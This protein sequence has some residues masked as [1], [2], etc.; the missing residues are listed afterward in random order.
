MVHERHCGAA[1]FGLN[2]KSMA[3]AFLPKKTT[4]KRQWFC[5]MFL[6]S[7]PFRRFRSEINNLTRNTRISK[8]LKELR[9]L[10]KAPVF[11]VS[12]LQTNAPGLQRDF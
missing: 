7:H 11:W 5:M 6:L 8:L 2:A 9:T 12:I 10:S 1:I 3:G 4:V